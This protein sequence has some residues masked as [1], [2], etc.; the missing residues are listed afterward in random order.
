MDYKDNETVTISL[1][2]Y[3]QIREAN[4]RLRSEKNRLEAKLDSDRVSSDDLTIDLMHFAV[5]CN[6]TSV[7]DFEQS[8]NG[9]ENAKYTIEIDGRQINFNLKIN[10]IYDYWNKR[11][12]K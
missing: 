5:G 9:C 10:S 11:K 6:F 12:N 4:T 3:Q 7:G 8:Y 2:R 1:E